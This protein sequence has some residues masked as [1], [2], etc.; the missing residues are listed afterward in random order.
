MA[1]AMLGMDAGSSCA[2]KGVRG[3]HVSIGVRGIGGAV[4]MPVTF[5]DGAVA[6]DLFPHTAA[7]S[8]P[9]KVA[10]ISRAITPISGNQGEIASA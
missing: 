4:T 5:T 1:L 7:S 8:T 6:A 10:P 2:R 9:A 3:S